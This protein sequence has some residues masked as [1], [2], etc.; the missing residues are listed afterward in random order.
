MMQKLNILRFRRCVYWKERKENVQDICLQSEDTMLWLSTTK[1]WFVIIIIIKREFWGEKTQ[2]ST[3]ALI[4]ICYCERE[5]IFL[6]SKRK[7]I[8]INLTEYQKKSG[9][10]NS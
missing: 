8:L 3:L 2:S 10:K 5:T 7:I 1:F 6:I 4:L 9:M